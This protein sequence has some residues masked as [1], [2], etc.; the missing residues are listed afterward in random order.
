MHGGARGGGGPGGGI[1]LDSEH[2]RESMNLSPER[3]K[4]S[5]PEEGSSQVAVASQCSTDPLSHYLP[6]YG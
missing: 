3:G 2:E 5:L 4:N 1:D 6:D